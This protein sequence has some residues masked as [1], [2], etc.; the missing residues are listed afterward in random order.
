[1]SVKY[2]P[3]AL[4]FF[5]IDVLFLISVKLGIGVS[6]GGEENAVGRLFDLLS[7]IFLGIILLIVT[8]ILYSTETRKK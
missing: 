5:M 8:I 3:Y 1:M 2:W 4:F 6:R 7:A